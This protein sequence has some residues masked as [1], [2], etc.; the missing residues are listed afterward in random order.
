M[1]RQL[2]TISEKN[3]D[4]Y[5]ESSEVPHMQSSSI[6]N[7]ENNINDIE[8]NSN[9]GSNLVELASETSFDTDQ[10]SSDGDVLNE[11]FNDLNNNE[12]NNIFKTNKSNFRVNTCRQEGR[13]LII[14]EIISSTKYFRYIVIG[15]DWPCALIT[16]TMVILGSTLIYIYLT[17]N[18]TEQ[19]IFII[20]LTS[21]LVG[22]FTVMFADPGL[23]R[24]YHHARSRHWTWCDQCESYRPLKTVHCSTCKVCVAGYDHHCIWTGKCIGVGN[25][26]YFKIFVWSLSWLLIYGIILLVLNFIPSGKLAAKEML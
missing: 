11:D 26:S 4:N 7:S 9:L 23:V 14:G 10:G 1:R 17:H 21:T 13:V 19:I 5:D 6:D 20:L 18:Q 15:P 12:N 2:D 3:S 22:L 16:V 25:I 24:R 8:H